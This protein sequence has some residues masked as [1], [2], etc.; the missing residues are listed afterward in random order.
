MEERML[1]LC[2]HSCFLLSWHHHLLPYIWI[3]ASLWA[4]LIQRPNQIKHGDN[5]DVQWAAAYL[6]F[7]DYIVADNDFCSLLH[8]SGLAQQYGVNAYCPRTLTTLL[9]TLE[10]L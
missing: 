1:A 10:S 4:H 5:L 8:N 6:P 7:M 2:L 3:E 9:H